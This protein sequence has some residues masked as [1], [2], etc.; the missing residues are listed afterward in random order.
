MVDGDSI[1]ILSS[2]VDAVIFVGDG[3]GGAAVTTVVTGA[4]LAMFALVLNDTL[5]NRRRCEPTDCGPLNM[6]LLFG[7]NAR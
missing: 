5:A 6:V 1:P 3:V 7:G 4:P 2:L